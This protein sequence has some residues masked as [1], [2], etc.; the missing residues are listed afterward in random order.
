MRHKVSCV[1]QLNLQC[2]SMEWSDDNFFVK[3]VNN[4]TFLKKFV[5]DNLLIS[6]CDKNSIKM[7]RGEEF[8]A[9]FS[10]LL[11]R[12]PSKFTIEKMR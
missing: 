5:T 10:N 7:E 1:A 4:S 11:V 3:N 2:H 12:G 6:C 9:T 8:R